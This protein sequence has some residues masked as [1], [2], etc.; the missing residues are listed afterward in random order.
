MLRR[1]GFDGSDVL[2]LLGLALLLCGAYLFAPAYALLLAGLA[3]VVGGFLA[4]RP[5]GAS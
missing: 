2:L 1:P 4:A 3:C 5:P